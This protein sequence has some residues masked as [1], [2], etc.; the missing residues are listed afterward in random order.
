MR[1]VIRE[2]SIIQL[3]KKN[4]MKLD[5]KFLSLLAALCLMTWLVGAQDPVANYTFAGNASDA[6]AF[7]NHASVNAAYLAQDRFEV[8]NSAFS[9][10]G[11][12]GF[13]AAPNGAHLNTELA[14]VSFWIYAN[15]IPATG[16]AYPLSFG[17]WQERYKISL[18]AHGKLIWTTNADVIS[19]MDA[20]DGNELQVGSWTHV[21]MVHDGAMDLIYING[22]LANSKAVTGNLNATNKPLGIGYNIYDGGSYFNG[23][24]DDVIIYDGALTAQQVADLFAAQSV[25]PTFDPGVVADYSFTRNLFDNSGYANHA[26]SVDGR[27]VTDRFGFGSSATAFNGETSGITA[28][29]SAQL[30]SEH[31]TVSLWVN[32]AELPLQG[33]AYLFSNGGWQQRMKISLPA[34]GKPVFTTNGSFGCCSDLD[35]GD[36]NELQVGVW[37]HLVMVHDGAK[38]KIFV[39]GVLANE[40][41]VVGTLNPTTHP[42]GIGYDPI[43]VA[44]YFKGSLDDVMVY[45]YGFTDQE[46]A[47]LYADQSTAAIDPTNLIADFP[48]AGDATDVSQFGNHGAIDGASTTKDRFGYGGNAFQFFGMEG[49]TSSNSIQYNSDFATVSLWVNVTELPLQGEAYLLSN[50]GWQQRM[51]ISLPAHGKPVFTTNGSFGCCSDLD[52]GDGNELQVGV[53]THL[54]M[55]HDGAKNKIFVNGVLANEKDV[56]GTLNPT[57]HPLGIGYDPIDM[58]NYFNGAIDDVQLYNEGLTDQEVA[59][60]YAA[61]SAPPDFTETL[62]ANYQFAGN[63]LDDTEYKNNGWVSGAL[64]TSDRFDRKNNSYDFNG[65]G[66]GITSDNSAQLNSTEATVSLWVNVTELPLQGEAYLLSNGGWQERLK[67]SLPAH[68]KPV[69]TT[70]G[71]FGCCSDLDA[72]DGNELQVGVWTHLAMVHDGAKNKIFVNGVL[73]NEKEVIG[74]LNPTVHPL[75]IGY[76]P[77]DVAN[78]FNGKLDDVQIYS[79]GMT[80]QEVADLYALQSQVPVA[81][82]TEAPSAPLE[83]YGSAPNLDAHLNWAESMDNVGVTGY[84]VFQNDAVVMN[85]TNLSATIPALDQLT[86]YSFGV[87]AVDAAGNE[88]IM[89]TIQ[90]TT[91]VDAAP[92]TIPPSAPSNLMASPGATSIGFSWDPST[93]NTAVAGY[94]T[95]LDGGFVDSLGANQTSIF[96]GGLEPL[97]PYYFEVFAYDLAGLE[98]EYGELEAS[99]TAPIVTAEEGL[100]AH[101]PFDGNAD[102]ATPYENHGAAAGAVFEKV[103]ERPGMAIVFDGDQDSVLVPNAAQLISDY[104]SVSFW[105]RVDGQN[106]ENPEA[107]I[108]DFGHWDQRWKISLPQHLKVVWTTNSKTNVLPNSIHDM[109]SGDGNELIAGFWWYVTMVHDGD[110]D[111]IYLDGQEVN[112]QPAPGELNSTARAF[113]MGSCFCGKLYFEGALDEVKVYNKALTGDEVEKLFNTG[114]TGIPFIS[115]SLQEFVEVLYPNPTFDAIYLEHTFDASKDLLIRIFDQSGRQVDAQKSTG[116]ALASGKI[117]WD[118]ADYNDGLYMLN[119]VLGGQNLGSIPFIKQ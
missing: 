102:D 43:D 79:F 58:A 85:T 20:G 56:V 40:K 96:I 36:G 90:L 57:V 10:D 37:T 19:D 48:F 70:N 99:T 69:F 94:V 104:T 95:F 41:D 64:L 78:Y 93:D 84:N 53:W 77:I 23:S 72:G 39:N 3:K 92:D 1:E 33:E 21:V 109:D 25:A 14:S 76:D 100:V 68:G 88:S 28:S 112:R 30:N 50:G 47:D 9:F 117:T 27:M 8:A 106:L 59:D 83:L 65:M 54:A 32:V 26:K 7:Q 87:V 35:A 11:Q 16:E 86:D 97:T 75:G 105:V 116:S 45:N 34:H 81:T 82:D 42:L 98:S 110:D 103:G 74:T 91:G 80:D 63:A 44:N 118:V 62:V 115:E 55:V 52:A 31:A 49:I 24:L 60:L 13:L 5:Y 71:S 111:I 6:T 18:P 22:V 114:T 61:Q 66:A 2:N 51:K 101:Y 46:V 107:F 108:L 38:N 17:G 15:E 113:H 4:V 73:A 29:S 89:T 119:F 67:I 12:R